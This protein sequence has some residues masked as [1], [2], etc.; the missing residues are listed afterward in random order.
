M[1]GQPIKIVELNAAA[2]IVEI[3]LETVA[4]FPVELLSS[5]VLTVELL[6]IKLF[7][8]GLLAV[9]ATEALLGSSENTEN[10]S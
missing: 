3:E 8:V 4:V 9:G 6:V 1:N 2:L 7:V 10:D 5:G